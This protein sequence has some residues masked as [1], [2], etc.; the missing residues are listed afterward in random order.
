[1][2]SMKVASQGDFK[3]SACLGFHYCRGRSVVST[4]IDI[5][6]FAG[7]LTYSQETY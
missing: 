7:T 3:V 1:M 5:D 6:L 2:E 4:D